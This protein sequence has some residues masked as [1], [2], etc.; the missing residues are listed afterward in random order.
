MIATGIGALVVGV[1]LLVAN[2]DK[3]KDFL[4]G[5]S[6]ESKAAREAL[7]KEAEAAGNQA[8]AKQATELVMVG[9]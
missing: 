8:I 7:E 4:S 9:R 6:A 2:F 5:I 3:I 1:G